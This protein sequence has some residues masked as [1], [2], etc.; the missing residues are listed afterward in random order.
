M[1]DKANK[2]SKIES[3][4]FAA[5]CKNLGFDK[6]FKSNDLNGPKIKKLC[7]NRNDFLGTF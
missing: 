1:Q 6:S 2:A 4:N 5:L 3:E 7:K